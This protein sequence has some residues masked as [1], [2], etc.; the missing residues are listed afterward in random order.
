[1]RTF[2]IVAAVALAFVVTS[3]GMWAGFGKTSGGE[4]AVVRNGG[5]FD[6]NRI[7]MVIQPASGVTWIGLWSSMHRYPAQQRYYTM[8]ADP[9][10]G[11]R[12][13][14]DLARSPSKDGVEM[15]I[16]ATMYFTLNLDPGVLK[17][18]DEKYGT[19]QY[20]YGNDDLKYAWEG[21]DGW[22]AFFDGAVRP[23]IDNAL[24]FHIGTATCAELVSSCALLQNSAANPEGQN[25]TVSRIESAINAGLGADIERNLGGPFLQGIRFNLVRVTLPGPV[26]EAVTKAQA[27]YAGVSE[28]QAKVAQAQAEAEANKKRQ[29]GYNAC[30]ACAQIDM[31]KALPPGV[32]TYAPGSGV[33]VG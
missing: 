20:R 11:G 26:Q 28:A 23:V 30:P 9:Q 12:P 2:R 5:M 6:N 3:V 33:S 25:A 4:V 14:I 32:T 16:E 18:F 13:G 21:V 24:R 29:E 1:M 19:R 17:T 8:T 15:G 22:N 31:I 27:A 10:R 7:R